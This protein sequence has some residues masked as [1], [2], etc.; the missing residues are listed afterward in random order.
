MQ[1][2]VNFVSFSCFTFYLICFFL[3][4]QVFSF[5]LTSTKVIT[6]KCDI[7]SMKVFDWKQRDSFKTYEVPD[8]N[9]NV[10]N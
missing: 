6:N 2:S 5:G 1:S 8:G 4:T 9:L 7:L 10:I 3:V